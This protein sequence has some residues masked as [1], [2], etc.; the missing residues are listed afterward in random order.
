MGFLRQL[1]KLPEPL[2]PGTVVTKEGFVDVDLPLIGSASTAGGHE[3]RCRGKV[4]GRAMSFAVQLGV[5][6]EAQPFG[7]S[8]NVVYWGTGSVSSN[9]VE[10]DAL[11][12]LLAVHF[13]HDSFAEQA[14]LQRVDA[15]VVCLSG[16]PR[17][18]PDEPLRTKFFFHGE[19]EEQRYAEVFVNI[20][21]S[22][23][24]IQFHEKD[25]GY[26]LPLLRALTQP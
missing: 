7:D 2:L 26:R 23:A 5:D 24:V 12:A 25:P 21:A 6:W 15:Q 20:S 3:F 4:D 16:D 9:G 22:D 8:G 13:G 11:I 19:G 14:M 18:L 10:G 1:F 17:R